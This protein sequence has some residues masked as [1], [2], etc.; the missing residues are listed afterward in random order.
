MHCRAE[1]GDLGI[2]LLECLCFAG[3]A[4]NVGNSLGAS[5][6]PVTM[7]GGGGVEEA[8]LPQPLQT[9]LA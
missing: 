3:A 4:G 7:A 5:A 8:G 2:E 6:E 1:V 9:V